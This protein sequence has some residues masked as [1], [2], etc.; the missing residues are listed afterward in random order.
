MCNTLAYKNVCI[1][2]SG[3]RKLLLKAPVEKFL[4]RRSESDYFDTGDTAITINNLYWN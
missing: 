3:R 1:N 4:K 2:F